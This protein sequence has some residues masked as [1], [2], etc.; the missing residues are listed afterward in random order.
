MRRAK[1]NQT[2]LTGVDHLVNTC[3]GLLLDVLDVPVIMKIVAVVVGTPHLHA[4]PQ[5][6]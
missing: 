2:L 3:I 1:C 5:V 4:Q 6:P